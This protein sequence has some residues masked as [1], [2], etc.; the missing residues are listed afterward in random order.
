VRKLFSIAVLMMLMSLVLVASAQEKSELTLIIGRTFISDQ[1][2]TGFSTPDTILH[3]GKGLTLEVNYGRRLLG[4][5]VAALTFEVPF[6]VNFDENLHFSVNAVPRDYRSFFVTPSIRANVFPGAG[7]SPWVSVGGGFGYF[8][9]NSSLE[10][11][12]PNPGE[13]GTSTGVFQIGGGID[14]KVWRRFSV[15]GQ[16]RDFFAGVPQLNVD[17]GKSRQHNLFV[18]GGIVWHF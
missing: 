17:T 3:S 16:V 14:M 8:S 10:F 9:E 18:G 15:R 4:G 2:V 11:F 6:A 13:T 1:G 12:G 7:L 5:D